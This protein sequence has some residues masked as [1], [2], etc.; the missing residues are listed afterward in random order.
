MKKKKN[1]IYQERMNFQQFLNDL[2]LFLYFFEIERKKFEA[3]F[4]PLLFHFDPSHIPKPWHWV[5]IKTLYVMW[6]PLTVSCHVM[7]HVARA[8]NIPSPLAVLTKGLL[9]CPTFLKFHFEFLIW[10]NFFQTFKIFLGWLGLAKKDL[11]VFILNCCNCN[12]DF[13]KVIIN[14][15]RQN[16]R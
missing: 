8:T 14:I 16:V 4:P 12:L 10:F 3:L 2:Y 15:L 13:F 1:F 7:Y 5:M 11:P 9:L 6:S